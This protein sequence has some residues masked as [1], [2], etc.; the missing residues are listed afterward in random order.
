VAFATDPRYR[1][2]GRDVTIVV[3]LAPW[4]AELGAPVR[5]PTPA[6]DVELTVPPHSIAGRRLRLKG[7]GIPGDPPGDLYAEVALAL[8]RAETE[9]QKDAYRTLSKAFPGFDARR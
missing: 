4:E 8:P 6:G 3:R 2:D 1:V 9:E 5:V 7:R